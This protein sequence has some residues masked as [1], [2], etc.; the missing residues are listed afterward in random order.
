L[1]LTDTAT[2]GTRKWAFSSVQTG[3][4]ANSSAEWVA[5]APELCNIF[6]CQLA[7]L[8]NFGTVKMSG[9]GA[10]VGGS[11]LPISSSAFGDSGDPHQMIM[12]TNAGVTK[13]SPTGLLSGGTAF[14]DVWSHS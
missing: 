9:A 14:N 2:N 3:S 5:E 1:S 7:S 10:A 8:T 13:A 12:V 11:D 4:D 6:Y